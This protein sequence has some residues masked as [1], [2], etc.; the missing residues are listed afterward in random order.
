MKLPASLLARQTPA[1]R[2]MLTKAQNRGV[3]VTTDVTRDGDVLV[4]VLRGMK[5]PSLANMGPGPQI[6]AKA[7]QSAVLRPLLAGLARPP[8]PWDVEIV[9]IAPKLLDAA[10]NCDASAKRIVDD[11]AKFAGVDDATDEI[12]RYTVRQEHGQTCVRIRI[13][14]RIDRS[15]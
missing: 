4:I 12:V 13:G 9:R 14:P 7:A 2:A 1:V 5:M 15:T 11:L 6:R 10:T 8:L 3:L